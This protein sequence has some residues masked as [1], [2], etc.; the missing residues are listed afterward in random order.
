MQSAGQVRAMLIYAAILGTSHRAVVCERHG[1][2]PL[3]GRRLSPSV[4]GLRRPSGSAVGVRAERTVPLALSPNSK[5]GYGRVQGG[6]ADPR[7]RAVTLHRYR[8]DSAPPSSRLWFAAVH[9]PPPVGG[10]QHGVDPWRGLVASPAASR[11]AQTSAVERAVSV[12]ECGCALAGGGAAASASSLIERRSD[13]E[14]CFRNRLLKECCA[15]ELR[16]SSLPR[17]ED[18]PDELRRHDP[19]RARRRCATPGR[20]L[21]PCSRWLTARIS[22]SPIR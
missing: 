14:A 17:R 20:T 10:G 13:A 15:L 8:P 7:G 22:S 2:R 3:C 18:D 1:P 4:Y 19:Q 6:R 5:R 12:V 11:S 16:L 21:D 9:K